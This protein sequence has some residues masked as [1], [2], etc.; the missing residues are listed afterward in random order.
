MKINIV[1]SDQRYSLVCQLLCENGYD[2]KIC[3]PNEVEDADCLL[4]SVRK[5]LTDTELA[6]VFSKINKETVVLCGNDERIENLF[7][8]KKI[9]YSENGDFLQ[10]NASLTAEATVSFLHNLMKEELSGKTVFIS[11]YGRIGKLLCKNLSA[12]GCVI[13]CYARRQE[14]KKQI[15]NDGFQSSPLE[16]STRADIIINTVP[17]P[18]FSKELIEKIPKATK[19]VE[20]A[21]YPYG[22]E[23]MERVTMA[24]ALPGKILP[25]G[26]AKAVYDTVF[27]ILSEMEVE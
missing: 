25:K 26:A 6:Q 27:S 24:S 4:F 8:F 7:E 12:L 19:I 2:A 10:K 22:F 17:F 1:S 23:A 20:L 3:A 16:D 15:L 18:I 9:I 11:G 13:Y 5:E 21:S 14:I